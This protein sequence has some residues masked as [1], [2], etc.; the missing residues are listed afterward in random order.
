MRRLF[1]LSWTVILLHGAA[2]AMT[3]V[4]FRQMIADCP[5]PHEP[6]VHAEG[7]SQF[8]EAS[9]KIVTTLARSLECS[10]MQMWRY[11]SRI[12]QRPPEDD[13]FLECKLYILNRIYNN[14]VPDDEEIVDP[15]IFAGMRIYGE[16]DDGFHRW[17]W[18]FVM[19][20]DGEIAMGYIMPGMNGP[21]YRAIDEF[22]FLYGKYGKRDSI[23]PVPPSKAVE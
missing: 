5:P 23:R 4:E 10:P 7:S 14:V 12:S 17:L 15:P 21:P 9:E 22:W 16:G 8:L 3:E 13:D 18:P 1:F 11:I 20:G 2:E 6:F 19:N